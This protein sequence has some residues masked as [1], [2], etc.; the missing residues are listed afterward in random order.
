MDENENTEQKRQVSFSD[1]KVEVIEDSLSDSDEVI[2]CLIY[3]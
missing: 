2:N 3:M 1:D